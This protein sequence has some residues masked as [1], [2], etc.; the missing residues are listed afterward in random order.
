[1]EGTALGLFNQIFGTK[2]QTVREDRAQANKSRVRRCHFETMEPRQLLDADPLIVGV[3]YLEDDLGQ[4]STPDYFEVTF[5]GGA[6][7]TE[8]TQFVISGDQDQT[9][10]LTDGDMFFDVDGSAPGTGNHFGF[11]FHAGGSVGVTA[12]DVQG[13]TVS[14]DGLI[15]TVDV[16]NFEAGDKLAFTI[17]VDEVEGSRNDKIASGVEFEGSFF[18]ATFVDEHY[19]FDPL[20]VNVDVTLEDGFEQT[21]SEGVF[22]DE[23]DKLLEKG[24][25]LAGTPLDWRLD[26][27]GGQSDRTAGAI[28]AFSL[29]PKP[30]VISGSVYEDND[31]DCVHDEDEAGIEGVDITLQK[32]NS[33][34]ETYENVATTMTDADGDYEFGADLKL[35]P[36]RYR[37][38]ETQPDGYLDVGAHVGNVEGVE[39][40]AK[41][42]DANGHANVLSDI[43]IP[44]GGNRAE[45]YDFKEVRPATLAGNVYHDRNNDGVMNSGEEGLANVLIKVTRV[46]AKPGVAEDPFAGFE[47][48]TVATDANGH[49]EV[50]ALPPGV[51]EVVEINNYPA[52]SNPLVGFVDGKDT[53][54]K[55]AGAASGEKMNDAFS[56]VKLCAGEDGVEY[57]FGELKPVSVS[58]YVSVTTPEGNCIDPTD[59]NHE[60]ISGVTIQLFNSSGEMVADTL[61]NGDGF[62]SFENLAPGG[63]SVVEVQ[64]AAYLDGS[65]SIGKVNGNV[66]GLNPINDRFVGIALQSGDVGTMYNFCEHQVAELGGTVWHDAN[67]DGIMGAAEDRI[68]GVTIQLFNA[69]GELVGETTTDA[70]GKYLF[71][72]L[73]AGEYSVREIQPSEYVDGKDR[74][75]AVDGKAVGEMAND[76]FTKISLQGGQKGVNYDFGEILL[77]SIDGYVHVTPD[78]NCSM[79]DQGGETPLGGVTIQLLNG[80]GEM[81]AET[82]TNDEGFYSF[83]EL[84]PGAYSIQQI[85]PTG[86]F[87]VGQRA[88]SGGGDA[89][90]ENRVTGIEIN[91]GQKL[92]QYN[93]CE[94]EAAQISGRVWEDGPAFATENGLVPANYREQRDG[95]YTAGVDRPLAGVKME[96]WYYIDPTT[97]SIAPRQVKLSE[98]MGQYYSHLGSDGDSSVWVTTGADG[99]YD[100]QGLKAGNYIV[101]EKQPDG[102]VDANDTPG[103]TTGFTFNSELQASQAPSAVLVTMSGEQIMDSVV[104]IR[105]NSGGVSVQNNFSEVRANAEPP[106]LPPPPTPPSGNPTPPSS[107]MSPGLGLAGS[108]GGNFLSYIGGGRAVTVPGVTPYTWHLSVVNGGNP[109]G[110]GVVDSKPL[111]GSQRSR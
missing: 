58:G 14:D 21:Q 73:A 29:S 56:Q 19:T 42:K 2:N 11:Q 80:D 76:R 102:F 61:T 30:V 95:V 60:G 6:A 94:E 68:S 7:T 87:T 13:V 70:E 3:T 16:K 36:G 71:S 90:V 54:G 49:Y 18:N 17:D 52:G 85:Q 24:G 1:M 66:V 110:E 57:N 81:I 25:D 43:D 35:T 104:N 106:W 107:P 99:K 23:Y 96:L 20:N 74:L 5:Q 33:Q 32:F 108:Q 37:L 89:T 48:L 63:Y 45:N 100:F 98:V 103:S 88:G 109:R 31:L 84:L 8:M 38:V 101:L 41:S 50:N 46:G 51:Y 93:F 92:T 15:L 82:V 40:G 44:L 67:N 59:P 97:D 9:G 10:T 27:E 65:E 34:S 62:Y 28:A 47:P 64:P 53:V 111:D 75:G 105:V 26:N 22:F 77:G 83:G 72:N 12:D 55:V 4:D 39:E 86:L 91:S 69:A 78:G 79:D